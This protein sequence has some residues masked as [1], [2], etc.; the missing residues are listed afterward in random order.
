MRN[1]TLIKQARCVDQLVPSKGPEVHGSNN[2]ITNGGAKG[3]T[4]A[5]TA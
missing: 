5:A 1:A 4:H 2:P 3:S